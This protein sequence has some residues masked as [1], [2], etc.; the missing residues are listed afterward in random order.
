MSR[1]FNHARCAAGGA[2]LGLVQRP[3]RWMV[4]LGLASVLVVSLGCENGLGVPATATSTP[5]QVPATEPPLAAT[6]TPTQVPATEP[7]LAATS[8]PT[9]V[10]A[11]EPPL[12]ATSTPTQVP[13]T[14]PPP[15]ATSTPTQVPATEPPLAATSTPTQVPATE[16]TPA[17]TSTPTPTPGP[18]ATPTPPVV[19]ADA[20]KRNPSE[21]FDTQKPGAHIDPTTIW[22]DGVTMWVLAYHTIYAYDMATKARV[23]GKDFGLRQSYETRGIWSDGVT[24]WVGDRDDRKIYA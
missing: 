3:T 2:V 1:R 9:Q 20:F 19:D 17:A 6:S 12:A 18:T 13:A 14:E 16:P 8:T 24:M 11:T 10:P 15:A 7:P 22:S 5:T 23:P 21:D 4:W